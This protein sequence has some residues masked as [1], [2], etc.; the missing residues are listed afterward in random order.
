MA[1]SKNNLKYIPTEIEQKWQKK[2]E[3]TKIYSPNLDKPFDKAQGHRPFYN[4]MMFPYPS[5]EGMHV[6]NM[7]AFTGA[8]IYGRFKRMQGNDVFEPIGLDGF[9][10]HSENY[11]IKVGRHPKE[12][13][14]ISEKNFYRQLRAT[15]NGYDWSRTVETYDPKYYKWTQWLFIQLFKAGLAYRKKAPVNFCPSCKTV[16]ADEQVIDEK[17][18]RCSSIVEKKELEQWF[19]KITKYADRLLNGLNEIDWAEKIKIAQKQWIGRSEG[20]IINFGGIDVFTTRPETADGATFLV[21][22]PQH[23]KAKEFKSKDVVDYIEIST[24]KSDEER[25]REKTGVFT[26]EY[27]INP[28]TKKKIPVWIADYVLM[29]YGTGAIM[30]VP[31]EDERD[32]EFAEKYKIP[33]EKTSLSAKP[34]GEKVVNYHLRDWLISRQRYWGPPIPMINCPKCGWQPVPEEQ[35]PV[36][37]PDVKDWKPLG[38]GKSPLANHPEFYKANC[39]NCKGPATRETD[40][41]DTF[42][43]SA[44]YFLRYVNTEF[45]NKPFDEL[46]V[47]KWLPVNM[48]IGGPEHAVLHLLYSRF[49]TMALHDLGFIDFDEP[50]TKFYA[51]GLIIKDGAKMSKSKGNVVVPDAYIKKYGADALRCYLMFTG[52]FSMGGDFRDSG[53]EGMSRF[54]KRVWALAS[55]IKGKDADPALDTFMHKTIKSVTEDM[56]NLNYNTAI[57]HLMEY[58][59]ELHYFY[60]KYKILNIKYCKTLVLLLAS[61]APHIT[62]ELWNNLGEKSSIHQQS[63]P[64]YD[65]KL[66]VEN[67]VTI[68][69]Q[70]N[71]K[72]RDIL[73]I[74]SADVKN[75]KDV[76]H[77]ASLSANVKKHLDGKKIKKVIYVEGRIINFVLNS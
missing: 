40:V 6:G 61:L 4:L 10:I 72:V 54:L 32:R 64:A 17:C 19:F 29:G 75:Q 30:A 11:A 41:S 35:L 2:W 68:V 27:I 44:W 12:Q 50:F 67:E 39:P 16:L 65:S 43:D 24:N 59:N 42:L 47:K 26:G 74:K 70:V 53:I 7:Y 37:L 69:I 8:D 63:W 49:I 38:T 71:G 25:R 45:D 20:M 52:P 33:I 34:V 21:L 36:L 58:Y 23:P 28:L 14:K 51:H 31:A 66:L 55:G 76:E 56:E 22:S 77:F 62:E 57:A 48:Y 18:E 13:A 1:K 9:G 73:K 5:A 60:T 46:R 15:G 3:E